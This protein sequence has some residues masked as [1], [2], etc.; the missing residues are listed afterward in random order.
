[1]AETGFTPMPV[2]VTPS[3]GDV[4]EALKGAA[5]LFRRAAA[6]SPERAVQ[7]KLHHAASD[8]EQRLQQMEDWKKAGNK[9]FGGDPDS[10]AEKRLTFNA[11][12]DDA[13]RARQ[14]IHIDFRPPPKPA[15]VKVPVPAMFV[16]PGQVYNNPASAFDPEPVRIPSAG[17]TPGRVD[18][19]PSGSTVPLDPTVVQDPVD[20][21]VLA[22]LRKKKERLLN[23]PSAT[24]DHSS[25][26]T[27]LEE[28]RAAKLEA[29]KKLNEL[30]VLE[31]AYA[32]TVKSGGSVFEDT[33]ATSSSSTAPKV[34]MFPIFTPI[35]Q[36][37]GSGPDPLIES[38][39]TLSSMTGIALPD[40]F[41]AQLPHF[42]PRNAS[43]VSSGTLQ[44]ELRLQ[45]AARAHTAQIP[46][47]KLE[48]HDDEETAFLESFRVQWEEIQARKAAAT[49]QEFAWS[50]GTDAS[51]AV[52]TAAYSRFSWSFK[53]PGWSRYRRQNWQRRFS[54]FKLLQLQHILYVQLA[55][56]AFKFFWGEAGS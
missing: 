17:N 46:P 14:Q 52:S 35:D 19:C 25:R 33:N 43:E 8:R 20:P 3:T 55:Q 7:Q 38:Y 39:K 28:I 31:Q 56:F 53:Q 6:T 36:L 26:K 47:I 18:S 40:K 37:V 24:S 1:M 9:V 15:M 2:D 45:A 5:H 22:A 49:S 51:I 4:M 23:S 30:K 32:T 16:A 10:S 50:K 12:N 48:A 21:S 13:E 34:P 29:E 41:G 11:I 54:S 44:H 27:K 42:V